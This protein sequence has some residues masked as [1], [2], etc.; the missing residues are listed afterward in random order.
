MINYIWGGIMLISVVFSFFLGTADR[1]TAAVF[2]GGKQGL[3]L[4]MTIFVT[5]CL[6]GGVM[7]IAEVGGVTAVLARVF[8]PITRFLMPR[9]KKDKQVM[10]AVSANITANMLGLGNA[11]TPLGI[12]AMQRMNNKGNV[13]ANN[14]MAMFVV[15]NT[16]SVQ[17]VPTTIAALRQKAGAGDAMDVLPC[18]WISSFIAL[19]VGVFAAKILEKRW[20]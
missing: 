14:S 3:E 2:D 13:T 15:L 7:K 8:Y 1:V 16:A 4:L 18:I 17:L 20:K 6:W 11:A 19:C 9:Y 5:M 12:Q 10:N